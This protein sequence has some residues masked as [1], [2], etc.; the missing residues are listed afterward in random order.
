MSKREFRE[1]VQS[2]RG[3]GSWHVKL[4]QQRN[5]RTYNL[6][7]ESDMSDH[8]RDHETKRED[9]HPGGGEGVQRD[10]CHK[11]KERTTYTLREEGEGNTLDHN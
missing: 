1:N 11:T 5:W 3:E 10:Y 9:L 2:R 7:R 4:G 6:E 8:G